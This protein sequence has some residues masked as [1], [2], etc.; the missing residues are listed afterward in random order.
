[1]L[2]KENLSGLQ[3]NLQRI[4]SMKVTRST[5]R[6][7]QN[8][9]VLAAEGDRDKAN[10]LFEALATGTIPAKLKENGSQEIFE[11]LVDS[12]SIPIRLAKEVSERAEFISIITSDALTQG[13]RFAFLNRV[14][15]IDGEEFTF[16]T[17]LEGTAQLVLHLVSRMG[18]LS[19]TDDG[20]KALQGMS[21]KFDQAAKDLKALA[22]K[23]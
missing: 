11:G 12:Y 9:I 7:V 2:S 22:G 6:E 14:R 8:A 19:N 5:F 4:F 18:D 15:R 21:D 3:Q 23:K 17:D 16:I 13:D 20:K 10:K 1:M